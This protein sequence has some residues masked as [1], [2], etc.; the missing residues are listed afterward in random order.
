MTMPTEKQ[1]GGNFIL[2]E[3][4]CRG[5]EHLA[6]EQDHQPTGA[7]ADH[8]QRGDRHQGLFRDFWA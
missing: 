4:H 3:P 2:E 5:R 6:Q 8:A 7:L 1:G